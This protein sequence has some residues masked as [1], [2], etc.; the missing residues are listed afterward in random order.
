MIKDFYNQRMMELIE[1]QM[2]EHQRKL[3]QLSSEM[4]KLDECIGQYEKETRKRKRQKY[5]EQISTYE[6]DVKMMQREIDEE[7]AKIEKELVKINNRKDS[8]EDAELISKYENDPDIISMVN[9]LTANLSINLE[10]N[11][12]VPEARIG[13]LEELRAYIKP[14]DEWSYYYL[15]SFQFAIE[16]RDDGIYADGFV[17]E[18]TWYSTQKNPQL[19]KDYQIRPVVD[20]KKQR[21]IAIAAAKMMEKWLINKYKLKDINMVVAPVVFSTYYIG[22]SN[23]GSGPLIWDDCPPFWGSDN[24]MFFFEQRWKKYF[25]WQT[26]KKPTGQA[27]IF[28]WP[29]QN[30]IP[31]RE[32]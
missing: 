6:Q 20:E 16:V 25:N 2:V 27:V 19:F 1:L 11:S 31:F 23:Y 24:D 29:R 5:K 30:V 28:E 10:E 14:K 26:P 12:Y 9:A 21:C 7:G 32:L 8:K 4:D 18:S 3:N 15:Y 22:D 17:P 13:K